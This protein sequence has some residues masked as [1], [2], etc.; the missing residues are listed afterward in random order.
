MAAI[1]L[2]PATLAA[3]QTALTSAGIEADAQTK[4]STDN[5]GLT[6]LQQA[7]A[8]AQQAV[9]AAQ[10]VIVADQADLSGK[11]AQ[12]TADFMVFVQL[13]AVDYGVTLPITVPASAAPAVLPAA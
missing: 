10:A 11:A 1:V 8:T 2:S 13:A 4:L 9:V 7:A 6:E 5:A 12:T 3:Q